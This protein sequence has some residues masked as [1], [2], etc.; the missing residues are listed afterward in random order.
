MNANL[1]DVSGEDDARTYTLRDEVNG[2]VVLKFDAC[3]KCVE[4]VAA[5]IRKQMLLKGV[6]PV[7][8]NEKEHAPKPD[9]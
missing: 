2:T 8:D 7:F 1:C 9:A 4:S 3:Q 5:G 6:K